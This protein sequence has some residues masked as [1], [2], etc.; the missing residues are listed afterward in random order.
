MTIS[1]RQVVPV[2]IEA[3]M[4]VLQKLSY[5]LAGICLASF[6]PGFETSLRIA[7]AS[8]LPSVFGGILWR[9]HLVSIWI[10]ILPHRVSTF[11]GCRFDGDEGL[12]IVDIFFQST[13]AGEWQLSPFVN[14]ELSAHRPRIVYSHVDG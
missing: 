14:Q 11:Y 6:R 13:G 9:L 10:L 3:Q 5:G 1:E 8:L 7:P 12:Y 2:R 4:A